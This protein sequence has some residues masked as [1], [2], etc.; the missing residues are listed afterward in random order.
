[1]FAL[2][3][4]TVYVNSCSD[5]CE[6]GYEGYRKWASLVSLLHYCPTLVKLLNMIKL[7]WWRNEFIDIPTVTNGCGFLFASH[8]HL[9]GQTKSINIYSNKAIYIKKENL[10]FIVRSPI[11]V[12][13]GE[14]CAWSMRRLACLGRRFII[15]RSC[16]HETLLKCVREKLYGV[17]F[18]NFDHMHEPLTIVEKMYKRD[19]YRERHT[20]PVLYLPHDRMHPYVELT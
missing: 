16:M 10:S 7:K 6:P 11:L 17:F 2:H 15:H 3:N 14:F 5:C 4:C 20:V 13:G 12:K 8:S 18:G 19:S 9:K 1:M